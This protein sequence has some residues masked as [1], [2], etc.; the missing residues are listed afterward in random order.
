MKSF[1]MNLRNLN[2]IK[3]YLK[4]NMI[5]KMINLK[6]LIILKFNRRKRKNKSYIKQEV[7]MEKPKK[8]PILKEN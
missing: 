8:C 2:N 5:S 3:Y 1:K 7:L 4:R 6:T